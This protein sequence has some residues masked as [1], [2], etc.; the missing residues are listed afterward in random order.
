MRYRPHRVSPE[1]LDFA[2][3]MRHKQA[4]AEKIMWYCLRD[5]RLNGF[6]FRRQ[7]PV[8]K[9]VADFCC[10][11]C[12]VIVELDGTSHFE[13]EEHDA[14][15][16]QWL[17][18]QGYHVVRYS[19]PDVHQYL[20]AVLNNLLK[21]C[22]ARA[23]VGFCD[24]DSAPDELWRADVHQGLSPSPSPQSTGE[25]GWSPAVSERHET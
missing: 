14:E 24:E 7:F 1:L 22:E 17:A 12:N 23:P 19:N 25:R 3:G 13:Q 5:R 15:R 4:P 21:E 10:P 18:D 16:T 6:K 8:G 20:E 2:K 11:A 9:Y